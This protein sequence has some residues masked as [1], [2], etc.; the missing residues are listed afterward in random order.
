MNTA[1]ID[2]LIAANV[3]EWRKYRR[4]SQQE[5]ARRAGISRTL[6]SLIERNQS[7]MTVHTAY[8]LAV[9]LRCNVEEILPPMSEVEQSTPER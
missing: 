2:E 8:R 4:F 3:R 9:A 6:I 7:N 1:A 5:L